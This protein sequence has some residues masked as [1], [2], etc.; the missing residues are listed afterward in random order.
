M[1]AHSTAEAQD[2]SPDAVIARATAARGD[3]FPEW[4]IL[5]HSSPQTYDL[6]TRTGGYFHQYHGQTTGE[7]QLSGPMRE[8]IATPALCAKGDFRH[9]PNH[10]RRMYRMGLTNRVIMEA[11]AA[12]STVSGWSTMAN[13]GYAIME[14]NSAGYPYG[15]LPDGGEP[16]ELTPFPELSI[17]R[18]RRSG[19]G[20][21]A[22]DAPEWRY[23]SGIDAELARRAAAWLD[24]CLLADGARDELLGPGPRELIVVAAL[25]IRGEID[26]IA[27]HIR[28]AYGCGMT[29][30]QV[31][32]A[33]SAVIPMS[34]MVSAQL[35]LRAMR[36]ADA[37]AKRKPPKAARRTRRKR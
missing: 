11:A 4:K 14:A 19:G 3:I 28:R 17:G 9:A 18:V 25:C 34:G 37:G 7:Q 35:G 31:L 24:H 13:V 26:L 36:M 22:L 27:Q 33:I 6:V 15:S 12:F 8:L 1:T 32:E 2:M 30:R 5:A 10:I 20:A 16:K 21:A 23:A 29:R